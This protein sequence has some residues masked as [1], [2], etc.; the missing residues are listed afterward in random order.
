MTATPTF[1]EEFTIT[2]RALGA[3]RG[4]LDL[5]WADRT[6]TMSFGVSIAR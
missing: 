6:G 4:V 2:L 5:S 1:V 3:A